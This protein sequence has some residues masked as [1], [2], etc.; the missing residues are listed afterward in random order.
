MNVL[1]K[2][3]IE[4]VEYSKKGGE[5]FCVIKAYGKSFHGVAGTKDKAYTEAFLYAES[6]L[7]PAEPDNLEI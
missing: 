7:F 4:S 5:W 1:K 3:D 2:E 6:I